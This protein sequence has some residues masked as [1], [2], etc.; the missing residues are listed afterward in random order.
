L[1]ARRSLLGSPRQTSLWLPTECHMQLIFTE[2]TKLVEREGGRRG[3]TFVRV[4]HIMHFMTSVG[5][6]L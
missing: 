1:P 4:K 2:G 5:L 6:V 3:T